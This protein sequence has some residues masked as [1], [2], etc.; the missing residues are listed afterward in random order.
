MAP[1]PTEPTV[2]APPTS[3]NQ[4]PH[5]VD[6]DSGSNGVEEGT[7][8]YHPGGFHPVYLGDV[9]GGKYQVVNKIGYGRYSTV[10]LVKDLSKA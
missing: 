2:A 6:T 1:G 9:Y 5:A 8:A 7:N 3:D 10:W 4:N